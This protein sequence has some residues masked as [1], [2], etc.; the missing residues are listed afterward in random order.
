MP[1]NKS[2]GKL[3]MSKARGKIITVGNIING[4]PEG[5][6][7]DCKRKVPALEFKADGNVLYAGYSISELEK[8][9][10]KVKDDTLH[11]RPSGSHKGLRQEF[12]KVK[13]NLG[14][15]MK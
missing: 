10:R 2:K 5:W 6:L 12:P 15:L 3:S 4:E 7:F 9:M 11:R 1:L 14:R 13:S 8:I